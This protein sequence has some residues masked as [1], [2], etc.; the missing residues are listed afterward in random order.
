[1]PTFL[2]DISKHDSNSCTHI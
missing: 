2:Q 1:M